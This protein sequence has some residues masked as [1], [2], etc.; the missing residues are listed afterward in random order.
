MRQARVRR[1]RLLRQG[2]DAGA[3]FAMGE[4]L[5]RVVEGRPD[6]SSSLF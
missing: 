2:V 6:I 5:W 1:R 3:C 4:Q